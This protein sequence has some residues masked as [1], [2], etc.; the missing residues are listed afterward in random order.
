MEATM[1]KCHGNNG[2]GVLVR[3]AL[4]VVMLA[5]A[6]S[7]G[8]SRVLTIEQDPY[9]NTAMHRGRPAD[10]RTGQPLEMYVVCVTPEDLEKPA[11]Q[12]L[13]PT[14]DITSDVWYQLRA[15][16]AG[17]PGRF[18]VPENQ[19]FVLT[20]SAHVYGKKV[21]SRLKG[22]VADGKSEVVVSGISFDG[23]L[24]NAKSVIY[25]FPKFV[26]SSGRVLRVKPAKWHPPGA[27]TRNLYSKIGVRDPGGAAEQYIENTTKRHLGKKG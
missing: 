19:I 15:T 16:R 2:W 27:F 22:A 23:P 9:I 10:R 11:N 14:F 12:K 5:G 24:Y 1:R 25:A 18:D 20:D 21:G 4:G 6:G 13:D 17:E 7:V 8:C 3:G 26:D